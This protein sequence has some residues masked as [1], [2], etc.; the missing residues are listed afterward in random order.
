MRLSY[1]R[2]L[3]N[4]KC[5]QTTIPQKAWRYFLMDFNVK[6]QDMHPSLLLE[7]KRICLKDR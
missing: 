5:S 4:K 3:R 1:R 2:N 6:Q 7:G